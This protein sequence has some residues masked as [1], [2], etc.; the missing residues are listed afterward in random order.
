MWAKYFD[1]IGV[2]VLFFSALSVQDQ[3]PISDLAEEN[4]EADEKQ[5]ISTKRKAEKQSSSEPSI[6][7]M[8]KDF[9]EASISSASENSTLQGDDSEGEE[10][11]ES[12]VRFAHFL[13]C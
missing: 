7:E 11:G 8:C 13:F 1:S 12:F 4:E 2:R 3:Y 10:S 6:D 5:E 9:D